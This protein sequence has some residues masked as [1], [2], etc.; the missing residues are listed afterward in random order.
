ML[1][2][3][4]PHR[5]EQTPL[6][7]ATSYLTYSL[8][9]NLTHR[10]SPTFSAGTS[11]RPSLS[12]RY[13]VVLESGT[14]FGTRRTRNAQQVELLLDIAVPN[15]EIDNLRPLMVQIHGGAF[16]WGSRI[17][18]GNGLF[19]RAAQS[20]SVVASIDY[21]LMGDDPLS[22]PQI[23]EHRFSQIVNLRS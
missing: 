21:R 23:Q 18:F 5:E 19:N 14:V 8:V 2:R 11:F 7:T 15:T 16:K 6:S 22:G 9:T 3:V 4:L 13:D 10:P 12:G 20:C 1:C 17:G